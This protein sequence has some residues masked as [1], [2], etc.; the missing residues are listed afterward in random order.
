MSGMTPA[1][2]TTSPPRN[3]AVLLIA[4]GSRRPEANA[5]LVHLA[6][7]VRARKTYEIVEI[8]YL[9]IASPS[10]PQGGRACVAQGAECVRMLP[11]FLSAGAHVEDDLSRFQRELSDEFP[12]VEFTVCLPLGLHPKIVDVVFDRL[13]GH[14]EEEPDSGN[15]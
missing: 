10:I 2:E 1:Q 11:Y 8:A 15:C 7:V 14:S 4:H 13:A 12:Q 5:D 6:A 9:E 3:T